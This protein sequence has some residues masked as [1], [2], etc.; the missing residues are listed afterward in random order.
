M[1]SCDNCDADV[2]DGFARVFASNDGSLLA[3]PDCRTDQRVVNSQL[4]RHYH[5]QGRTLSNAHD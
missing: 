4:E 3:C 5:R 1:R 2:T